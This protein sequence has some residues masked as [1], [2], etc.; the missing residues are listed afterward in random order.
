MIL[1]LAVVVNQAIGQPVRLPSPSTVPPTGVA[2]PSIA[3]T[4]E[5]YVAVDGRDD[6]DG[7]LH[8]PLRTP[9]EAVN[10]ALPGSII[11]LRSGSYGLFHIESSGTSQSPITISSYPGERAIVDGR[12]KAT[13]VVSVVGAHDVVL[14][15]ITIQGAVG[16]DEGSGLY[17]GAGSHD[18]TFED[19]LVRGIDG[20]GILIDGSTRVTIR[21]SEITDTATGIRIRTAGDQVLVEDNRIFNND[22][23]VINDRGGNNDYGAQGVAFQFTTGL[24]TV[25]N[26]QIYGQRAQSFDYGQD[27]AAFEVFGASNLLITGNVVW[28]NEN[29]LETGTDGTHPCSNITFTRNVAYNA[30]SSGE[31]KGI[32]LRCA[33]HSLFAQNTIE[34]LDRWAIQIDAHDRTF[35]G[36]VAGLR[37]ANNIL[38]GSALLVD[39][40]VPLPDSASLDYDLFSSQGPAIAR[41]GDRVMSLAELRQLTGLE[42][43]GALGDPL[44]VDAGAHNYH[45]QRGSPGIDTGLRIPGVNDAYAGNAPDVGRYEFE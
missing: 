15:H 35:G 22:R 17:V 33:A 10:R 31:S 21:R 37:I 30:A 9:Q 1:A 28:D 4:H 40:P 16:K 43:H 39:M 6:G 14:S 23:M 25:R 19:G 3:A 12:G 2:L 32:I 5:I 29:V 8:R 26:N 34:G 38:V 42:L 13:Q 20:F 44:F 41:L 27:G 36:P 24:V 18:V 45:L 7:S 11:L